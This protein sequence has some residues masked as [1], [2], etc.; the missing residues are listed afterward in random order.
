M[1]GIMITNI[2]QCER[3]TETDREIFILMKGLAIYST[4]TNVHQM[5]ALGSAT[6]QCIYVID[7]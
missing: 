2:A 6:C 7:L 4:A 3:K 1:S 5:A